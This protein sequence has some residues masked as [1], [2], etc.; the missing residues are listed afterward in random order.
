M[1]FSHM[2]LSSRWTSLG[3]R[4]CMHVLGLLGLRLH[5]CDCP[6]HMCVS[7]S[8]LP[9]GVV[10]GVVCVNINNNNNST[11]LYFALPTSLLCDTML[12]YCC[13]CTI[14]VA[15]Q[16][17]S[18]CRCCH[19]CLGLL[20]GWAVCLV[21]GCVGHVWRWLYCGTHADLRRPCINIRAEQQ[22]Q[23]K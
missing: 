2:C 12:S 11:Q 1:V 20:V 21:G 6:G 19:C 13:C 4:V 23:R 17:L 18:N 5:A 14:S 7:V 15:V 8:V 9:G 10:V 3:C 16:P 22:T